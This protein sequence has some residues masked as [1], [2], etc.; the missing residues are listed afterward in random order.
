VIVLCN[1]ISVDKV[2]VSETC[3]PLRFET[4]PVHPL[5]TNKQR[6]SR[7]IANLVARSK[8]SI[9][10][11]RTSYSTFRC[12]YV[13][14]YILFYFRGSGTEARE[15][16]V[17]QFTFSVTA[18]YIGD[19]FVFGWLT[20]S[21]CLHDELH[22]SRK[23]WTRKWKL[24]FLC[25]ARTTSALRNAKKKNV[26]MNY[27]LIQLCSYLFKIEIVFVHLYYFRFLYSLLQKLY[28][29]SF[30]RKETLSVQFQIPM[31]IKYYAT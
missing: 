12:K 1:F 23:T 5:Q 19:L 2:A 27:K 6:L 22:A 10:T 4:S 26:C 18:A 20:F 16:I 7:T 9:A 30:I 31:I 14:K 3:V 28:K 15:N 29:Y 8:P 11:P 17:S 21:M 25:H 13:T 24:S